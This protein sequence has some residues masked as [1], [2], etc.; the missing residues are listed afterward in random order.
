MSDKNENPPVT[1]P[2]DRDV[3]EGALS[4]GT[5]DATADDPNLAIKNGLRTGLYGLA[6]LTVVSL[7]LWG[8]WKGVPGLWGVLIG[9]GVGGG[10]VLVTAVV[11][12]ASR[13]LSPS[14]S[15]GALMGSWLIKMVAV[16]V[17]M[18]IIKDM[19]FYSRPALVTTLI[20]AIVLVLGGEVWG[21]MKTK[22]AYVDDVS[23][24]RAA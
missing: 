9:A 12:L 10:F 11:V 23:S 13:N 8:P 17:V 7:I 3:P 22:A 6:I 5:G 4:V 2:A 18:A 14:A 21:V 1:A 19:D 24:G 20:G 15:M 16:I